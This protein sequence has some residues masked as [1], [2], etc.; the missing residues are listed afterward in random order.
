MITKRNRGADYPAA[1]IPR[2]LRGSRGSEPEEKKIISRES[3]L[4]PAGAGRQRGPPRRAQG[5]LWRGVRRPRVPRAVDAPRSLSVAGDQLARVALTLLVF[6][7]TRSALLAAVA[8]A[9]SVVP[10]FVGGLTLSGLADRWPRRRVMIV[11]DLSPRGCW[12]A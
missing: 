10:A 4:C 5:H 3:G 8:F 12:S 11:C 6:D 2:G 7:Q 1:L 9:A